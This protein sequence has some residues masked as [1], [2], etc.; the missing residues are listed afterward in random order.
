MEVHLYGYYIFSWLMFV[1]AQSIVINGIKLSMDGETET[2]PDGTELDSPMIFYPVQKFFMKKGPDI[3]RFFTGKN[4][5]LFIKDIQQKYPQLMPQFEI[6]SG[7]M[8]QVDHLYLTDEK[9]IA[10]FKQMMAIVAREMKVY[11][12]EVDSEREYVF[13]KVYDNYKFSR[14]VRMPIAQCIKCMASFWS[15]ILTYFPPMF[16]FIGFEHWVTIVLLWPMNVLS[17]VYVNYLIYKK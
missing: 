12:N 1:L 15:L 7:G 4:F 17:L 8:W 9:A 3:Q 5:L 16:Y 6:R 13:Y 11:Y 2:M 14:W 10:G